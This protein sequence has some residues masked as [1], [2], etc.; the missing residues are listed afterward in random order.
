MVH[1]IDDLWIAPD[2]ALR[3]WRRIL[4]EY[5]QDFDGYRYA[6]LVRR[7]ECSEV[8]DDVWRLHSEQGRFGGSYGDLRCALFWLQRCVHAAE[9]SPGW[10]PDAELERRVQVLYSNI[11]DEWQ[12]LTGKVC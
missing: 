10:Q 5:G 12:K 9:Q 11:L 4:G 2:P 3:D 1:G 7:R 8:A 6:R